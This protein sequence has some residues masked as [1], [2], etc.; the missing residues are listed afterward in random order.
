MKCLKFTR[1]RGNDWRCKNSYNYVRFKCDWFI[2]I[3]DLVPSLREEFHSIR[4]CMGYF[5]PKYSGE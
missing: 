5:R 2:T 3:F 4:Q 1:E